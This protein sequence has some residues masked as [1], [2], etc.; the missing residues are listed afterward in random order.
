ML[1]IIS[2]VTLIVFFFVCH[3][4]FDKHYNT[5]EIGW[6]CGIISGFLIAALIVCGILIG[7]SEIN[8]NS[9]LAAN[10]M[11]YDSLI[12]QAEVLQYDNFTDNGKKQLADEIR[13]WNE[14]LAKY[15]YRKENIW[16]NWF[17]RMDADKLEFIPYD[18]MKAAE[19]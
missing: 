6:L 9:N 2:I 7:F 18:I 14:D 3:R 8:K 11:R 12:Y 16:T 15:K 19:T 10:Q 4:I 1:I 5:E 17:Y 13:A